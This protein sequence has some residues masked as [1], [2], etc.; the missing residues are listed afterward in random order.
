MGIFEIPWL[1]K[2]KKQGKMKAEVE[3]K[4]PEAT[5]RL[6]KEE[7]WA[8]VPKK[9]EVSL[10]FRSSQEN[11]Y[12]K[13]K[14]TELANRCKMGDITAMM[15]MAYF[16]RNR[17]TE[18]L[19]ALLDAYEMQPIEEN[20]NRIRQ[21]LREHFHE[22]ETAQG[23]MMWLVRAALYGNEQAGQMVERWPYYKSDAYISY[24]M[25]TSKKHPFKKIWTSN[26]LW[27]IGLIDI[28]GGYED[29]GLT[30]YGDKG[31]FDFWYV[32]NYFPPDEDGFG[33]EWDYSSIYYDEFF[34]RLPV[35]SE[36]GIPDALKTLEKV[37]EEYWNDPA[38]NAKERKYRK[39]LWV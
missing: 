6:A 32:D 33:A 5:D 29:C 28:P 17:C 15:D 7:Q 16:F 38:R 8:S 14:V 20:E 3:K 18:P 11:I 25:F 1:K 13:P 10:D 23:Y 21:H 26:F 2:K 22:E 35:N 4:Q 37:R 19:Q 27:K 12:E 30:V 36:E 39:R 31:Y 24:D 9:E 34:C